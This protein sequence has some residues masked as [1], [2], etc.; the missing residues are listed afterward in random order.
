MQQA[1]VTL[2]TQL[3]IFLQEIM[4]AGISNFTI[5]GLP[6]MDLTLTIYLSDG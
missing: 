6:Y 5:K 4:H 3:H 1:I 2:H